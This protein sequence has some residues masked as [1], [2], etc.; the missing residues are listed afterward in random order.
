L[1]KK[2]KRGK[3]MSDLENKSSHF[4][5][6]MID[7]H[8]EQKRFHEVV[9]RFPPEPNGYL[10]LGHAKSIVLNFTTA[11]KYGG[12]CHL[13]FD[14]TNPLK[15]EQEFI[16][17]IKT[18]VKWLGFDW[19]DKE[20]YASDYFEQLYQWAEFLIKESKAYVCD[21]TAEE[22]RLYRGT[23]KEPG[24]ES[25]YRNRSVEENLDLFRKMRG[26]EFPDGAKTLRAKIDMASGNINMRDPVLYRIQHASHPRTGDAWCIY[27][28]YDYAHGQ[29]DSLEKITHSICTLEFEDHRPLYDWLIDQL[30]IHHP[31]QI[32]FARL[33][34]T[35]TVLSKRKLRT[36]VEEGYVKGWDDPR[37]PTLSGIRRRGYTPEAIKKFCDMIGVAKSNSMVDFSMLEFALRED[38]NQKAKRF[39]AVFNPIK[40]II[41]NFP[42]N[43]TQWLEAINNPE[44][45]QAGSRKIPF[46]KELYIE[47]EDFMENPFK[48]F[49]RLAPG[50]EVRLKFAYYIKC[51]KVVKDAQGNIEAIY[52]TYDPQTKGGWSADGRKVKG[53]IHW[54]A[55]P[56]A[57]KIETRLYDHLFTCPNPEDPQEDG[58]DF[59]H[60]I[61]PN[62]LTVTHALAEPEVLNSKVGQF[63]QFERKAYFCVD[64]DSTDQ[65][66]VF[67]RTIALKD[68]FAKEQQK[69]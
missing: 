64:P 5:H 10:H 9:T 63:Y 58:K 39:M 51:E 69:E 62:S 60:F 14:D 22:T 31:Q 52:C 6:N 43:E 2:N 27:P 68:S 56:H 25:P 61:N 21:L 4:I 3:N 65:Q 49:H 67:N 19:K 40:I 28:M 34:I 47:E 55:A 42:D 54:V 46:T 36:L 18:D 35:Y 30:E 41:T 33:N 26:G 57:V 66:K 32:E 24:K 45:E 23:L 37:M 59:T 1:D 50:K 48:K 12:R 7:T 44:N 38:L 8:L 11:Q 16:D 20:F 29:S 53:T 13:R 17:S 15:E